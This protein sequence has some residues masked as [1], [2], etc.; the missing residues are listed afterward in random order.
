MRQ[1]HS[2]PYRAK[3]GQTFLYLRNPLFAVSLFCYRPA[4]RESRLSQPV[5]KPLL[6]RECNQTLRS[7]LSCACF[8][9]I[10]MEIADKTLG[11]SQTE[12]MG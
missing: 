11:K 1:Q 12:G 2:I 10:L 4:A 7:L 3:R 8:P 9:P 6:S 5:G